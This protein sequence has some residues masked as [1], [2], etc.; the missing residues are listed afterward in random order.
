MRAPALTAA[1]RPRHRGRAHAWRRCGLDAAVLAG[2]ASRCEADF[3]ARRRPDPGL[4]RR[5]SPPCRAPRASPWRAETMYIA[6]KGGEARHRRLAASCWPRHAAATRPCAELGAAQIREQLRPAGGPRDGR[7]LAVRPRAGGAGHQAGARRR[8]RGDLPA[9]RLPH[10]AAA[11]GLSP[12]RS[13]PRACACAAACRPSSRTCRAAS[14]SGRRY[15]LHAAPARLRPRCADAARTEP[16]ARAPFDGRRR[17]RRCP[18]PLDAL[19]DEGLIEAAR[20]ERR[21]TP[22]RPTSPA[23]RPSHPLPRSARLQMLARADEGWVLGMGYS[24][25]RGYAY[26]HPVRRRDPLRR[27]AAGDRARRAR[28]CRS[29]SARSS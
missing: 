19:A 24:T 28:L 27:G 13:T 25:Q 11:P 21:A 9:A 4:R 22:S 2:R 10:H 16:V 15:R 14:C 3:P 17:M 12:S 23:T 1:A 5:G 18:A 20:A 26:T 8:D 6:V 7:G 29:R